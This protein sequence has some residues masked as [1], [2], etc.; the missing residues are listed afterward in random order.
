M[1][2]GLYG[3]SVL[4]HLW[5]PSNVKNDLLHFIPPTT[6]EVQCLVGLLEFFWQHTLH[7]RKFRTLTH[8]LGDMEGHEI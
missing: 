2:E 3:D 8:L 6:K 4:S 1:G 5:V 7:S